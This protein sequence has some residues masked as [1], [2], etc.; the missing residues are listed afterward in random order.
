[1]A[2]TGSSLSG[3]FSL[4]L[5]AAMFLGG[6]VSGATAQGMTVKAADL[7]TPAGP[8][9]A[10]SVAVGVVTGGEKTDA[11]WGVSQ[12]DNPAFK[13]ALVSSLRKAG[14]LSDNPHAKYVV[15]A[16]LIALKQ[17]FFGM[18]MKVTSRIRYTLKDTATGAVVLDE[19]VIAP[20]TA[21]VGDAF[22]GAQRLRLA[23]EGSARKSIATLI[24]KLEAATRGRAVK[25]P[26]LTPTPTPILMTATHT[27]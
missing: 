18:D 21:T 14:L 10:Q 25:T 27:L 7:K 4:S 16:E 20:Y 13:R 12:I 15:T 1:M 5:V 22:V 6:C 24:A 11:M 2:N 9:V 8:E 26:T 23:N 3:V 17:P 19:E